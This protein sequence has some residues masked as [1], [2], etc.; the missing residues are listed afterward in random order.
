MN[1]LKVSWI[2]N[3]VVA[4]AYC[5]TMEEAEAFA[6]FSNQTCEISEICDNECF[7]NGLCYIVRWEST[8]ALDLLGFLDGNGYFHNVLNSVPDQP[9]VC[10]F[11]KSRDDA[12]APKRA[13]TSDSGYD[14]VLLDVVKEVGNVKYYTTGIQVSPPNGYYFD[15]VAR[16]SLTK[17]GHI[18]ANSVGIIDQNYRGDVIVP[19]VKVDAAADDITCPSRLV[20]LVPRRWHYMA[21]VETS[22][23]DSTTRDFGGFGSTG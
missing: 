20:Q 16:S 3:K 1:A 15:L 12:V 13:H 7:A 8:E 23:L 9:L 19:L 5:K 22:D 4:M 2:D 14:L 21:M 11:K 17:T 18:L 6:D 10:S